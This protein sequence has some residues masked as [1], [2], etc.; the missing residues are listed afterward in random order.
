MISRK[1]F[2]GQTGI[3]LSGVLINK[4]HAFSFLQNEFESKRPPVSERKFVSEAVEEI[5]R[6]T[7]SKI[8]NPELA[9]LFGNCFK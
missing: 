7:K 3:A 6:N 5:I 8:V 2:I 4:R 1:Q 9:W